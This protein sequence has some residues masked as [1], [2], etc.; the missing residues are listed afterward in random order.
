MFFP[1]NLLAWYTEK[2]NSTQHK[3]AQEQTKPDRYTK[4]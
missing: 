2:L 3:Q 1:V 4:Y